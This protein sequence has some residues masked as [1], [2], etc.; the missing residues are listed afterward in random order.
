MDDRCEPKHC[1]MPSA[2]SLLYKCPLP[3]YH[4]LPPSH[5]VVLY[6]VIVRSI[7]NNLARVLS[8]ELDGK[9]N[10]RTPSLHAIQSRYRSPVP[11]L[12]C[13]TGEGGG[14]ARTPACHFNARIAKQCQI[15]RA[16]SRHAVEN[17]D[18]SRVTVLRHIR[19]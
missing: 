12:P 4:F 1:H 7:L 10:R 18:V 17:R 8:S 3:L 14:G 16:N 9:R 6:G 15:S 11:D 19:R 2:R 13:L 5:T